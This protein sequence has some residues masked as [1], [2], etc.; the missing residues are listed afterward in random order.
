MRSATSLVLALAYLAPLSVQAQDT[1]PATPT[2]QCANLAAGFTQLERLPTTKIEDIKDGCRITDAAINLGPYT[3]WRIAEAQ[4]T[5]RGLVDALAAKKLPEDFNL[6]LTGLRLSPNLP[7]AKATSYLVE[8]QQVPYNAH[9]AYQWDK[10]TNTLSLDDIS[11]HGPR[12][13][14]AS[15]SA[16]LTGLT[17][18][19]ERL[20]SPADLSAASIEN[21]TMTLNNHGVF[22]SMLLAPLIGLLPPDEDPRPTIAASQATLTTAIAALSETVANAASK[23]ALTELIREFPA[24]T[25]IYQVSIDAPK[26]IPV[27]SLLAPDKLAALTSLVSSLVVTASHQPPSGP[28]RAD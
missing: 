2:T 7:E 4:L 10:A 5:G 25:G 26:P 20:D 22:Q 16:R 6:T 8:N 1:A 3:R 21:V 24:P 14:L 27:S 11:I 17:Q 13:G 23:V 28:M 18:M 15:L 9:F 12:I 19:P